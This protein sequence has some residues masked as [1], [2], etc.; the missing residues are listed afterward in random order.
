MHQEGRKAET[1]GLRR[2][3]LSM[4]LDV[5]YMVLFRTL[6]HLQHQTFLT[7][8]EQY[9][10]LSAYIKALENSGH[11]TI[12]ECDNNKFLNLAITYWE[13][14]QVFQAYTLRG[15]QLDATFIKNSIGG[16]LLVACVKDGN[17][18]I[19]IVSI[20]NEDS[21]SWFLQHVRVNMNILLAFVISDRDRGLA[22]VVAHTFREVPHFFCFRHLME[23]F[24]TRFKNRE[25]KKKAWGMAKAENEQ[26]FLQAIMAMHKINP[27][28]I[29]WVED[30]GFEKVTMQYSPVCRYG[31][32]TSNNVESVN[33][34]FDMYVDYLF[35]NC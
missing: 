19:M 29:S 8:I 3:L 20:E 33:N 28:S 4:G 26:K 21:W 9:R 25:L 23:N 13:G 14:M 16:T 34:N 24:N 11:R 12:I 6:K 15:L 5:P 35:W 17:N 31:I 30:V 7:D 18:N 2:L 32:V 1:G 27:L 10:F 22:T